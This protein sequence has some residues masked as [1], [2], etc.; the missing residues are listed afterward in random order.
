[1]SQ[2]MIYIV[3]DDPA[4]AR[5]LE[6]VGRHMQLP[7]RSFSSAEQFLAN[8]TPASSGCLILDL[9]L[10]G[11][12]G[13]DL[14]RTLQHLERVMPVILI[15]GHATVPIAVEAMQLGVVTVL[16]KPFR[17]SDLMHQI[18][19]AL[20]R[21]EQQ[22]AH[23]AEQATARRLLSQLTQ[24]ERETLR[25]VLRGYSNKQI[26]AELEISVRAVEDRRSRLMRRL[27]VRTVPEAQSLVQKAGFNAHEWNAEP[28]PNAPS[29]ETLAVGDHAEN[30]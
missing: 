18:E 29:H 1:M 24:R 3:D 2:T 10:Q 9:M 16:E 23:Y 12:S 15:S 4:V 13:I 26:A 5:A 14:L 22:R 28:H 11:Q 19:L 7:V 8:V 20:R 6:S 17:L 27:D 21:D 30:E 25:L